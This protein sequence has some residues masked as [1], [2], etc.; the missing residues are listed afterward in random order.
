MQ[1]THSSIF[2]QVLH[3][4]CVSVSS[5]H[6]N[7]PPWFHLV[8]AWILTLADRKS[9]NSEK[10]IKGIY[11][12]KDYTVRTIWRASSLCDYSGFQLVCKCNHIYRRIAASAHCESKRGSS[13][14]SDVKIRAHNGHIYMAFH[15]SGSEYARSDSQLLRTKPCT[16]D[17]C[18][19]LWP[20]QKMCSPI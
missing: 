14:C 8:G 5:R 11:F 17:M 6:S 2:L 16:P 9:W 18:E 3:S 12:F 4:V 13:A 19:C 15:L 1:C 10:N 7:H 20:F